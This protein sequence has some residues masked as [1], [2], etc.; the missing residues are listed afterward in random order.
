MNNLLSSTNIGVI[1][2][3]RDLRVRKFTPAIK[4]E[5]NLMDFDIGRPL[6]HISFNIEYETLEE[7]VQE[8]LRTLAPVK[9]EVRGHGG[10][11]Y[12]MR[13]FPYVTSDKN[14]RGVVLTFVDVTELKEA[15]AEIHKLSAT[16]ELSPSIV[17]IMDPEGLIEY[18]NRSFCEQ[19]G[20]RK[21]EILGRSLESFVQGEPRVMLDVWDTLKKEGIWSG[22]L[23]IERKNGKSYD[24]QATITAIHDEEKNVLHYFKIA[25][26][27]TERIAERERQRKEHEILHK[28]SETSPVGITVVDKNGKVSF[29]N[30]RAENL[31]GMDKETI[32][33]REFNAEPWEITDLDGEPFPEE[34]LPFAKVKATGEA[35][36][37]VRHAIRRPDGETL[38]LIIHAS[39]LFDEGGKFDGAVCIIEDYEDG[40]EMKKKSPKAKKSEAGKVKA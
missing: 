12:Y 16:V 35:V 39:P 7:D 27:V 30:R 11:I 34:E 8:V 17:S 18:V 36:Y 29:A 4:E 1:F 28:I 31:F 22:L 10:K 15:G 25:W 32:T 37:N 24:E 3:D 5:I 6:T 26:D 20:Y 14:I 21:D 9:K 40:R 23:R 19:T 13:I 2:L 33:S 38:R